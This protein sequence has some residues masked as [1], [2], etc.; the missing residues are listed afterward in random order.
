M[1]Q[2]DDYHPDTSIGSRGL[3]TVPIKI[4]LLL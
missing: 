2:L 1:D 4:T 3:Y